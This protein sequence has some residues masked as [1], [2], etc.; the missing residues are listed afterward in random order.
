LKDNTEI[1]NYVINDDMTVDVKSI[2]KIEVKLVVTLIAV[3]V[4]H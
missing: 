4:H 3:L 1:G 2:K